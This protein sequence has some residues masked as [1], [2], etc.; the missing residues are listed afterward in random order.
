MKP[1]ALKA[2]L[3]ETVTEVATPIVEAAI[4][5]LRQKQSDIESRLTSPYRTTTPAEEKGG[6]LAKAALAF[7][8]A[9]GN[10]ES[11]IAFATKSFGESSPVVKALSTSVFNAGGALLSPEF[12]ADFIDLLR[13]ATVVLSLGPQM[14]KSRVPITWKK[15][16]GGG[17]AS[18]TGENQRIAATQIKTGTLTATPHKI[19]AI[20]AISNELVDAPDSN[21]SEIVRQDLIQDVAIR[22]DLAFIRG[23]GLN[24]TPKG[25]RNWAVAANVIPAVQAGASATLDEVD[26]LMS[27]LWLALTNNDVGMVRPGWLWNPRTTEYLRKIKNGLGVAVYKDDIDN[28]KFRGAPFKESTQIPI[29]LGGGSNE[30]EIYLADFAEVVCLQSPD[31]RIVSSTEATYIDAAGVQHNAMQDDQT[32]VRITTAND[33]LMQHDVAVAVGTTVKWGA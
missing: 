1:E 10:R 11:A 23:D 16:T 29:T 26:N 7:A 24:D 22:S 17:S 32:V 31:V 27:A 30:S 8:V 6:T 18:Y 21:A 3:K 4:A 5:P 9:K 33:L 2:L 28:G 20:S 19:A 15:K 25:F 14:P 13:P 12:S